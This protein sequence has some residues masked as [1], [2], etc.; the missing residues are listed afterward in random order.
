MLQES[1][2]IELVNSGKTILLSEGCGQV[3]RTV[4]KHLVNFMQD[5]RLDY[6]E[7]AFI[8]V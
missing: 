1:F 7:G 3:Q 5:V 4:T 8:F 2:M 6:S